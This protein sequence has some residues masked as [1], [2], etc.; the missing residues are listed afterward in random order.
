MSATA[1][2]TEPT[3][4]EPAKTDAAKAAEP[5]KY[6]KFA[7]LYVDDEEQALKYFAKGLGKE[8]QVLTAPSVAA[9]LEILNRDADRIGVVLTDQRMPNASG[10]DLLKEIRARWP[11]IVRIMVTAFS[12]LDLAIEAVNGGQI[13]K[14]LTKPIEFAKL[15]EVVKGAFDIFLAEEERDAMLQVKMSS[16]RRMVV[17]DRVRSLNNLTFGLTHHLRNS[18]TAMGCFL[19]EC[20]PANSAGG[21]PPDA[22]TMREMWKL[23]VD[24]RDRLIG[25]L[26][27]FQQAVVDPACKFNDEVDVDALMALAV[28]A[29]AEQGVAKDKLAMEVASGLGKLKIDAAKAA[30]LIQI[31]ITYV[32]QHNGPDGKVSITIAAS[33][34]ATP[35]VQVRVSGQGRPWT[36]EDVTTFFTPFAFPKEDPSETGVGL[37]KAF[38]IAQQHGGDILVHR[39]APLGP[40]F[41]LRLPMNADAAKRPAVEES[42]LQTIFT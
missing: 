16:L 17:E 39:T 18:M 38:S 21:A 2:M 15:R 31:L 34:G 35:L 42:L 20:D 30:Q 7:V 26:E 11:R 36:D 22:E 9:A 13:Y 40:G 14:Y 23:A 4:I 6:A 8:F 24:E 27:K 28:T 41:E 37:L 19:E 33:N 32:A 12:E 5:S 1:T 10:T 25:M 3:K 29:A